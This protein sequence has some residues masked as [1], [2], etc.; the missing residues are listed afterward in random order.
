M[1]AYDPNHVYVPAYFTIG[2]KILIVGPSRRILVMRRCDK[3]N[4]PNEWDLPGGAVD[5]E[6]DPTN[7]CRREA[8]EETGLE[9][10]NVKPILTYAYIPRPGGQ[11][12]AIIIGYQA[13]TDSED[14]QLSW[15]HVEYRWLT[16]EEIEAL[17][18]HPLQ[19]KIL[20]AFRHPIP[21]PMP[22]EDRG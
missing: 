13:Q 12:N 19:E 10:F 15:E 17:D 3:I 6:E 16:V 18:V 20:E 8:L 2:V 14:V 21:E 9:I 4:R 11:R 22:T 1:S 7:A 5:T